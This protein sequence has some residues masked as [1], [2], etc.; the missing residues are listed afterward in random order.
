MSIFKAPGPADE[1]G[2]IPDNEGQL[3]MFG[4]GTS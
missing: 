2:A 1:Q 4:A 3:A